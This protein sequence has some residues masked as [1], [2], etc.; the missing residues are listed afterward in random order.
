MHKMWKRDA[1]NDVAEK[2]NKIMARKDNGKVNV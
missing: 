2:K 1:D